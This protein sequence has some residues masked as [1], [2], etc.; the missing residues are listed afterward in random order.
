MFLDLVFWGVLGF[1]FGEVVFFFFFGDGGYFV[2]SNRWEALTSMRLC[3]DI[4]G[5]DPMAD[6]RR[7][8]MLMFGY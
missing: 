7:L 8:R 6:T 5:G 2:L 1:W 3:R 4:G